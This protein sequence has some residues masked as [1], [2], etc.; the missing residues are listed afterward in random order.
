M[1][2][3]RHSEFQ[4]MRYDT[5]FQI[6]K[7]L[8]EEFEIEIKFKDIQARLFNYGTSDESDIK[9]KREIFKIHFFNA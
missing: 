9:E 7:E 3:L 5:S 4:D 2:F 8:G 1:A 6:A